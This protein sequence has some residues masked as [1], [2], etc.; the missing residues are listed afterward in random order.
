MNNDELHRYK[1]V[2]KTVIGLCKLA[3]KVDKIKDSELAKLTPEF[4]A[5][6]K[7]EEY[8]KLQ[9]DIAEAQEDDEDY[10]KDTDPQG[11]QK[12]EDMLKGKADFSAF[13][14]KVARLSPANAELQSAALKYMILKG[15][16]QMA[17]DCG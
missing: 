12:Y 15:K 7:S 9:K 17:F 1:H 13:V 6:K 2:V 5:W 16:V 4:E 8:D 3:V 10:K 14:D 11:F